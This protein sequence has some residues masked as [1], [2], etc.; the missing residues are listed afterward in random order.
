MPIAFVGA[1]DLGNRDGSG[2]FTISYTCGAGANRLLLV[3][4]IGDVQGGS[5]D[6]TGVT[7]AGVSMSL[8]VKRTATPGASIRLSLTSQ[9]VRFYK[10][11]ICPLCETK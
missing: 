6:I 9:V 5:D 2:S 8:V 4:F 7:S 1:A 3:A 11:V 10:Y